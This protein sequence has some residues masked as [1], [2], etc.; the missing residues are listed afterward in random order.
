[1]YEDKKDISFINKY[2]TEWETIQSKDSG[3]LI[4]ENG[5]FI[6]SKAI[7]SKTFK[8]DNTG[9]SIVL[10]SG[11]LTLVSY[12]SSDS[13]NGKLFTQSFFIEWI[14]DNKE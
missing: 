9:Y 7:T 10:G 6:F 3:N 5:V 4:N 13:Y 11:D 2:K 8:Q 12:M 1:M 14:N